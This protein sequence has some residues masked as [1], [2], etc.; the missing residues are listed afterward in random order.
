MKRWV[1]LWACLWSL[2]VQAQV[3]K[4]IRYVDD[5]YR[6]VENQR[7]NEEYH[8]NQFVLNVQDK[9]FP[10]GVRY[11]RQERYFYVY[12]DGAAPKLRT[13]LIL[14]NNGNVRYNKEFVYD[15]GDELLFYFEGQNDI[16]KYNF[17]TM[18]VY[19]DAE[20][21][22]AVI[23]GNQQLSEAE[24]HQKYRPKAQT[25]LEEAHYFKQKFYDQQV[26]EI[27]KLR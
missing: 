1:L 20:K 19:F 5:Y 4:H 12:K 16:E 13:I 2:S 8:F 25:I 15:L 9:L 3:D 7:V 18:K 10:D 6:Y 11:T 22:S 14:I 21:L 23:E 17:R 24:T 27:E 26:A